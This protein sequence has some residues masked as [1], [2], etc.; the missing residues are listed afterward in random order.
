M[1]IKFVSMLTVVMMVSQLWPFGQNPSIGDPFIIVNKKNNQLAYINNGEIQ[2]IYQVATGRSQDLTPEG[3][4]WILVKAKDPFYRKTNIKGGT[5]ENPLGT[6]WIGFNANDTDGRIYGIHGN[7]N[8]DSIG[9][10]I[11]NG[12]I[13]MTEQDVQFLFDQIPI[14]T[15]VLIVNSEQSFK[16]L[17]FLNGAI[18]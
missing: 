12:C 17:A 16:E 5:K 6:R 9:K 14:G 4:F 13:R 3:S 15:K 2:D 8:P 10:Y 18:R 11:T 7:N 1:M